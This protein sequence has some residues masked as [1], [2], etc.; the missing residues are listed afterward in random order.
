VSFITPEIDELFRDAVEGL[1]DDLSQKSTFRIIYPAT[2]SLCPNCI[3]DPR[4]GAS[5][6]TYNSS[7]PRPFTGKVCPVCEGAGKITTQRKIRI[8]ARVQWGKAEKA[9][10]NDILPGGV[11]P[12][13][14]ARVKVLVRYAKAIADAETFEVDGKRC[15]KVAT[16]NDRGLLTKVVTEFL[17]KRDD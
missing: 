7:G 1:V 9:N 12:R 15:Q 10:D 4:T 8:P 14:Y 3:Y 5:T 17:V 2:G 16:E 6:G 13:G 11:L